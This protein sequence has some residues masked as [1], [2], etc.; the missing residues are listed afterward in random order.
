MS[1]PDPDSWAGP[2]LYDLQ[3]V[4]MKQDILHW[5]SDSMLLVIKMLFVKAVSRYISTNCNSRHRSVD[6]DV[7]I[8]ED[9]SVSDT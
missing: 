2:M 7:Q 3:A 9:G 4:S 5:S 6:R 8:N 1:P